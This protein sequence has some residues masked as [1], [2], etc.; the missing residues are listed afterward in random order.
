M[1]AIKSPD[2]SLPQDQAMAAPPNS[3]AHVVP[4]VR[5]SDW[6]ATVTLMGSVFEPS[7]GP[8]PD[9]LWE[10]EGTFFLILQ[11]VK[12]LQ[13]G[14]HH[15]CSP[16]GLPHGEVHGE[17]NTHLEICCTGTFGFLFSLLI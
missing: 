17:E 16:L 3:H 5:P 8:L 1:S 14:I 15:E 11:T 13:K 12:I 7:S 4:N 9:A 10:V 2:L 6:F